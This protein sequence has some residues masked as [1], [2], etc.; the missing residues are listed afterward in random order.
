[1]ASARQDL[2]H[3]GLGSEL[4]GYG[5]DIFGSKTTCD[6]L[7]LVTGS[8]SVSGS[9]NVPPDTLKPLLSKSGSKSFQKKN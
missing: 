7:R 1:M 8:I 9:S 4:L 3:F 6:R 5:P 2:W